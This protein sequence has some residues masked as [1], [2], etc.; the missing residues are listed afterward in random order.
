MSLTPEQ[1]LVEMGISPIWV[2]RE[3]PESPAMTEEVPP[4]IVAAPQAPARDLQ[5]PPPPSRM[6]SPLFRRRNLPSASRANASPVIFPTR[7]MIAAMTLPLYQ[8]FDAGSLGNHRGRNYWTK[9]Q[10]TD[11]CV[12]NFTPRLKF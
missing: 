6:A 3:S 10:S 4:A 1:M 7:A 9:V 11:I 8:I 12:K 5:P 2:L